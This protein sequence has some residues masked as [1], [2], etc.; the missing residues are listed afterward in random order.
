MWQRVRKLARTLRHAAERRIAKA[1]DE[2][3][4]SNALYSS[5]V[6]F[7]GSAEAPIA[8]R[9]LRGFVCGYVLIETPS[10]LRAYWRSQQDFVREEAAFHHT[11]NRA[12]KDILRQGFVRGYV[13]PRRK[14]PLYT[15]ITTILALIGAFESTRLIVRYVFQRPDVLLTAGRA[16]AINYFPEQQLFESFRLTS[17]VP[18][19]QRV[20]IENVSLQRDKKNITAAT[21][22]PH[23]ITALQEG[24]SEA[25]QASVALPADVGS[26]GLAASVKTKAGWLRESRTIEYSMPV[27]IWS[28]V[29]R[30]K[31]E[32][33]S[34]I[35]DTVATAQYRL[36]VGYAAPAG[37]DCTAAVIASPPEIAAIIPQMVGAYDVTVLDTS[38]TGSSKVV[39]LRWTTRPFADFTAN[40]VSI[41]FEAAQPV[42]WNKLPGDK[43]ELN[44]SPHSPDSR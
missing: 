13:A 19:E 43:F 38:G 4:A 31:F 41:I 32:R 44:C 29:P 23:V 34:R 14:V 26:Y 16:G 21:Y 40:S 24:Q 18:T 39:S 17:R 8:L 12:K 10:V 42:D 37:L 27:K 30:A 20:V 6:A 35:S 33:W 36:E 1:L 11:L 7:D 25:I 22:E 9:S 15:I 3:D 5:E 2:A 28:P